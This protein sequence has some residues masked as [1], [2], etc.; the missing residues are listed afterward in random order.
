[1][2]MLSKVFKGLLVLGLGMSMTACYQQS[3]NFEY[4]SETGEGKSIVPDYGLVAPQVLIY[5]FTDPGLLALPANNESPTDVRNRRLDLGDADPANRVFRDPKASAGKFKIIIENNMNA[6][7][8]SMGFN[9]APSAGQQAA[10]DRLFPS[11]SSW[12]AASFDTLFLSFFGRRPDPNEV[13]ILLDLVNNS[14]LSDQVKHAATCAAALSSLEA[15]N[16]S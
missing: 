8:D 7:A 16:G 11:G 13:N 1:M 2:V 15:L 5:N 9:A 4:A 10:R 6:C 3:S 12:S 14:G